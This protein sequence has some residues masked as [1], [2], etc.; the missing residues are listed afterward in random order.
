M[1]LSRL[2]VS[3][4]VAMLL[5]L[6]ALAQEEDTLRATI[7]AD[8]MSDPRSSEMSPT[9]IDALVS[10]LAMQAEEQGVAQDYLDAQNSFAAAEA[11]IYEPAPASNALDIAVLALLVV[12]GAV[13]LYLIWQRNQRRSMPPSAGMVA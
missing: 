11:P 8:I 13:A 3:F 10:A 1:T 5:P 2:S 6:F 7:R 12:L 9:E 4:L